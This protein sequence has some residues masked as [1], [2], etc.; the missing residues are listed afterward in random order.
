[1]KATL[2][3]V[4]MACGCFQVIQA[5]ANGSAVRSGIGPIWVGAMSATISTLALLLV[6]LAIYRLPLPDTSLV[7]AQGMKVVAGGM[8]GAFIV[9]G[10]AFVAPRLGPTQTFLLYFFVVAASSALIDG[11]GLLGTEARPLEPRQLVGV[12]LAGVGLVLARA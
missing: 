7:M 10:L 1:L 12:L 9:A 2:W 6:A 11:F 4:A 8:M 5:M 3:F